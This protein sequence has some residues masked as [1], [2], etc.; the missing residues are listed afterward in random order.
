MQKEKTALAKARLLPYVQ[1]NCEALSFRDI[2]HGGQRTKLVGYEFR[3]DLK[4]ISN[5]NYIVARAWKKMWI[6]RRLKTLG[7]SEQD[8]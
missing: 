6:V 1:P 5:T 2:L 8:L 3:M 7:A 4:T